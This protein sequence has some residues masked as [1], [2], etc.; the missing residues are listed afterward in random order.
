MGWRTRNSLPDTC[1]CLCM[2]SV[3]MVEESLRAQKEYLDDVSLV[4]QKLSFLVC[5]KLTLEHFSVCST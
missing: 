2:L 1:A 3:C 4:C 5:Q